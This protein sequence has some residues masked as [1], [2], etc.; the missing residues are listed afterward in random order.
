MGILDLDQPAADSPNIL[1]IGNSA[2]TAT[3]RLATSD[4]N[5]DQA[6]QAISI[7]N[8]LGVA[9]TVV[10]SDFENFQKLHQDRTNAALVVGNPH[11]TQY[12]NSHP[13]AATVSK[14]DWPQMH[15]AAQTAEQLNAPG[16]LHA[17]IAGFKAAFA[18]SDEEF[19][20]YKDWLAQN[21]VFGNL[22]IRQAAES[23]GAAL[24]IGLRALQGIVQGGA[25][26]AGAAYTAA[27]GNE[28][29]G[30]R[31]TRDLIM[32]AQVAAPEAVPEA[33]AIS[34]TVA[35]FNK[36]FE[37]YL[38]EGKVPPPGLSSEIDQVHIQ[39]AEQ[40][41]A[42]LS[43][44]LKAA[45]KTQTRERSPEM[46]QNL[47]SGI[48]SGN[49][50][51]KADA[52]AAL[53]GDKVPA[54]DDGILGWVPGISEQ[55]Q[56]AA[57]AGGDIEIPL[58]DWLAKVDPQVAKVLEDH[59][60]MRPEGMT[61]E[62]AKQPINYEP[63][64]KIE[65]AAVR[66][67]DQ[68]FTA[69]NHI[70]ALEQAAAAL[71]KP[72]E[73]LESAAEPGFITNLGRYVGRDEAFQIA[74]RAGQLDQDVLGLSGELHHGQVPEL[75]EQTVQS[76]R[77]AAGLEPKPF[78][79]SAPGLTQWQT[80]RYNRL[81]EQRRIQDAQ[82]A[83]S[84]AMAEQRRR[85]TP[86]WKAQ[87]QEIHGQV[88]AET[89]GDPSVQLLEQLHGGKLKIDPS[90]MT[91]TQRQM[92]PK[93]WL[94]AKGVSAEDIGAM[95][96]SESGDLLTQAGN[97][98]IARLASGMDFDAYNK[99]LIDAEA[100][101]RMEAEY[102]AL[103]QNI[104]DEAKD[105]VL[106]EVQEELLHE[107]TMALAEQAGEEYPI[108]KET[109]AEQVADD[110]EKLP[111]DG[112]SSDKY[113]A[114]AGRAGRAMEDAHLKGDTAE[115]FRQSQAQQLSFLYAKQARKLEKERI[116]F[117]KLVKK[118]ARREVKGVLPEYVNA[119][120]SILAKI[121]LPIG[122][123]PED[124]AREIGASPYKSLSDFVE[125][126]DADYAAFGGE[127]PV[128]DFLL[129]D[130]YRT[131]PEKMSVWEWRGLNQSLKVLDHFGRDEQKVLLK[132]EKAD[133]EQW[134][135]D[136]VK[137]LGERFEPRE[138]T[139]GEVSTAKQFAKE[140]VAWFHSLNTVWQ[141][142][143]GRDPHGM[144]TEMFLYPS[145]IALNDQAALEREFSRKYRELG[146]I[147]EPKRAVDHDFIDPTTGK[148]FKGMTR[149]N[150]E[151]IISNIG[152]KYNL[153]RI[154]WT[155]GVD[156]KNPVEMQGFLDWIERNT[157]RE[158][159]DRAQKRGELFGELKRRSDVVYRNIYGVAPEDIR[160]QPFTI[161]GKEYKGWYHPIIADPEWALRDHAE[162]DAITKPTS[163]WPS[164]PNGYV[165]R[166]TGAFER[167][168]LNN[169]MV[170][171]KLM[172]VVHDVAA[173]EFVWNTSK[174][175]NDKAFRTGITRYYGKEYH[176]IM[177]K[178]LYNI[179]GNASYD[180]MAM[181]TA[182]RVSNFFRQ[183]VIS[184]YIAFGASTIL[185]HAPTAAMMSA[186]ELGGIVRGGLKLSGVSAR[187]YGDAVRNM[188]GRD[189][190]LGES[191]WDFVYRNSEEI[192]LR[193]RNYMETMSGAHNIL[194]GKSTL[195]NK[196]MQW[197]S[198]GVALSDMLS[199]VP[200][201]LAKYEEGIAK[202]GIHGVAVNEADLA[203]QRAH[204]ST[205]VASLPIIA[206]QR[207][208]LAPWFTSLYG[209]FGANMQRKI[210]ILHDINDAYKLGRD[211]E[212][213][214]AIKAIPDISSA[215]LAQV[216][217]PAVVEEAVV[218]QFTDDRRGFLAKSV[219]FMLQALTNS[220]LG[221][222][223]FA[224]ALGH[225][226]DVSAGLLTAG[227]QD[228][229]N[230]LRDLQKNRPFSRQ[231]AGKLIQDSLT[232]FGDVSG[233]SP[234]PVARALR[235]GHD[236]ARGVQHPHSVADWYRGLASGQQR[237]RI[238]H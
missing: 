205:N 56:S 131:T 94:S 41:K 225:G 118:Y 188:F 30:K 204:G 189:P 43:E 141:R 58:A 195:R 44:A 148:K 29:W 158:D 82:K 46:F 26:A 106:S 100:D 197:G 91:E 232:A 221:V 210:E 109:I 51:V 151:A 233:M 2:E 38:K 33:G 87:R 12:V 135:K 93:K 230:A 236:V 72:A 227:P 79:T 102:G 117:K 159:I 167:L 199:A 166:R 125:Q 146:G 214:A 140:T 237:R 134:I 215:I 80:E 3:A 128:A 32:G 179:A 73:E 220:I 219:G 68:Y 223:D 21:P 66:V 81:I 40:D 55:L 218:G 89:R 111:Q 229:L 19:Q 202:H 97:R 88:E 60:R 183:N 108:R 107:Q 42:A 143:D 201:W 63:S 191:L 168:D 69:P 163:F 162:A 16:I 200:L 238:E 98:E 5:P 209:F 152:N 144:F 206:S 190:A 114:A 59:V 22:F 61:P 211:V 24:D 113:M 75:Q 83:E 62:E 76:V 193:D 194:F 155:L 187:V 71:G 45:Q 10:N 77:Q 1:S 90:G 84:R 34:A 105:Q 171:I 234:K 196:I 142:F 173:R 139:L 161:H 160:L 57:P 119:V 138:R 17:G 136:A 165:K 224:W 96:N 49:I 65:N 157:T 120:H 203:V 207:G 164:T 47:T 110:F 50:G 235:Y 156:Y 127:L 198:H 25:A 11:L 186:K 217:W 27:G 37:P 175:I 67:G 121:G 23:G 112:I 124:L 228:V 213:K 126:K 182:E 132:G 116:G 137:Q 123:L 103:S 92:F 54:P 129:D 31:L 115:A 53:Y 181:H 99:R 8:D 172:Q 15:E 153:D 101:R 130:A 7:G 74:Q 216:I 149:A 9:P 170:P 184:T 226:K 147:G 28:A 212:I 85:L 18:G 185:K 174:I 13:L 154:A 78:A 122:R 176:D 6:T 177:K 150:L 145:K 20:K 39:Q 64:E 70:N 222:R 14:D 36:H 35:E 192:Q 48:V 95:F 231:H 208:V 4:G 52:V 180:A 86:E 133:R 178:W 104:L 169:R